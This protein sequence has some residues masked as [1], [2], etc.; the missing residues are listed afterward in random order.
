MLVW[1]ETDKIT[2]EQA[3]QRFLDANPILPGT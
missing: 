1:V 3:A 2:P